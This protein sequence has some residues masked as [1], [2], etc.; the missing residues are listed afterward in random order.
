M[1]SYLNSKKIDNTTK[2]V[3][4]LFNISKKIFLPGIATKGAL[5]VGTIV[6]T[7]CRVT[8][9]LIETKKL[10][11]DLD[12]GSS[13]FS[14]QSMSEVE[15]DCAGLLSGQMIFLLLH[16]LLMLPSIWENSL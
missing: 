14:F 8:G 15:P 2:R 3:V 9:I 11:A 4:K 5:I 16:P 10:A 12:L 7:C 6:Y 1:F 13:D